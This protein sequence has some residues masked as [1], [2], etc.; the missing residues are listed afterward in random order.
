MPDH[1]ESLQ[2]PIPHRDE[3]V[4]KPTTDTVVV[5]YRREELFVGP[6]PPPDLLAHYE[7]I[8][9][10]C[11]DRILSMTEKQSDHRRKM[12]A[13]LVQADIRQERRGQII[14]AII[15]S[16]I[17]AGGI[18]LLV[19]GK[20]VSGLVALLTPLAGLASLFVY[21]LKQRQKMSITPDEHDLEPEKARDE[22]ED[23]IESRQDRAPGITLSPPP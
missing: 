8:C 12:E 1:P 17:A 19:L 11:A 22:S 16:G 20:S 14:A 21:S 3:V 6:L 2:T 5:G 9:P 15:T 7:K 18:Y 4:T 23:D 10:G 13:D